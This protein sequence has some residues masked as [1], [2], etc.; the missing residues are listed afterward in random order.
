MSVD[1]SV[2][3]VIFDTPKGEKIS[4]WPLWI[5]P[6]NRCLNRR[7]GSEQAVHTWGQKGG[8]IHS[9]FSVNRQKYPK[10][11]VTTGVRENTRSWLL[12]GQHMMNLNTI[13]EVAESLAVSKSTVIRLVRRNQL[14]VTR[15]GRAVRISDESLRHFIDSQTSY[16][17]KGQAEE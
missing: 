6:I 7:L 16:T 5:S 1:M 8:L 13:E 9:S 11:F 15:I 4:L 12:A 10:S 3:R 14:A 17:L 2:N